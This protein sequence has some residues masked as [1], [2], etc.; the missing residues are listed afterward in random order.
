MKFLIALISITF[1]LHSNGKSVAVDVCKTVAEGAK[2]LA[3]IKEC[4]ESENQIRQIIFEEN[5]K[6]KK[7]KNKVLTDALI[8]SVLEEKIENL[9]FIFDKRNI[10]LS[11]DQIYTLKFDKC[12]KELKRKGY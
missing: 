3:L 9:I 10:N 1:A 6:L 8:D 11:A 7:E 2:N 12:F 4:G 5:S